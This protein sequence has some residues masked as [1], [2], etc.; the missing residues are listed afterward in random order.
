[1]MDNMNVCDLVQFSASAIWSPL[2]TALYFE[3]RKRYR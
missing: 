2:Q 3:Y 1:M